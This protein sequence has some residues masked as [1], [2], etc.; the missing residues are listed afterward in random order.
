MFKGKHK[1]CFM[2]CKNDG[3]RIKTIDKSRIISRSGNP[4]NL[5]LVSA[6]CDFDKSVRYPYKFSLMIA[7]DKKG[8]EGEGQFL[9]EVYSTD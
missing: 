7:N 3:K 6:E 9:C 2:V 8:E 4:T 1:I 5:L